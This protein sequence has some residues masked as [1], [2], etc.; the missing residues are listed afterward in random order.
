MTPSKPHTYTHTTHAHTTQPKKINA[1][2]RLLS[3][4]IGTIVVIRYS[5]TPKTPSTAC[6][7][8]RVC[9]EYI[10]CTTVTCTFNV[11]LCGSRGATLIDRRGS[12]PSESPSLKQD[13]RSD[14]PRGQICYKLQPHESS[15]WRW[16]MFLCLEFTRLMFFF[17]ITN[18]VELLVHWIQASNDPQVEEQFRTKTLTTEWLTMIH[19]ATQSTVFYSVT[20]IK[21]TPADALLCRITWLHSR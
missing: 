11:F 20:N 21:K 7:G 2:E 8:V 17:V 9:V 16:I 18:L 4:Y 15:G 12:T 5:I 13:E 3:C 10:R 14:V 6:T 19:Q 1:Y